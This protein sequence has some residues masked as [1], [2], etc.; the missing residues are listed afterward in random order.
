MTERSVAS[1]LDISA[2]LDRIPVATRSHRVWAALLCAVFLFELADL[3]T[4]AYVAPALREHWGA[5]VG[6]IGLV[7]SAAFLGMFVGALIGG[8]IADNYGRRWALIGSAFAYSL[9]SLLSALSPNMAVLGVLRVLTGVGLEALTVVGLIYIAEMFPARIR[10]RHQSLILG[11]GLIGIPMMSWFARL[12]VPA[13]PQSWRWVFVLGGAGILAAFAMIRTLP[14]SVR[15]LEERGR[16]AR[17]EELVAGLEREARERTGAELPPVGPAPRPEQPGRLGELFFGRYRSRTLVLSAAW[18]F[19]ILG[20]YGFNAWVPTLLAERGYDVKQSLTYAAILSIG[21]VPGA[22]LAW[23]VIDRW[24]RKYAM[25]GIDVALGA[26]VLVYGFVANLPVILASGL[27]VT[28]LL[29]MHTAFIYTYTPEVFPT[30]LRGVGTGFTNG[31]GRL[32]GTGGGALVAVLFQNWGYG[33]VFVYVAACM[34]AVGVLVAV[35]GV[36]T[37]GRPLASI[38]ADAG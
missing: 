19:G 10:G 18:V 35:F 28:L 27:L 11:I 9:F 4:F 17:A 2:R 29:Q 8:R 38:T 34:L 36:R 16:R 1:E 31:L 33:S 12:V 5:T 23:P 20:F 6:D 32:A 7:T 13:G 14:E 26:L 22:L 37:T 24:E 21:A 3:N 15:W 25:L 30:R